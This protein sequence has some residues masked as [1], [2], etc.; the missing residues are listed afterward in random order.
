MALCCLSCSTLSAN[1]LQVCS[2]LSSGAFIKM[3]DGIGANIDLWGA[4]LVTGLCGGRIVNI[5]EQEV[6]LRSLS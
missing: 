6:W 1:V 4:Q 3:L 2:A 5:S